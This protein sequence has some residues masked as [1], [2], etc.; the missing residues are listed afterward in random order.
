[1]T[2]VFKNGR[3]YTMNQNQPYVSAVAVQ[4]DK[5]VYVGTNEGARAYEAGAKVIDLDG[6]MMIPG[7]IDA[8]CHPNLHAFLTSGIMVDVDSTKEEVL[9]QIADYVR[10]HPDNET[11][12]GIG[13]PEW[14]FD[15]E[16]GPLKTELDAICADKPMFLMSSG[17]HEGWC[18]SKTFELLNITKETPD[19]VPGFSYFRRSADGE[20][21]GHI[22]E[23]VAEQVLMTSL[24]FFDSEKVMGLYRS[25]FDK[26]SAMGITGF[27]DC[28]TFDSFEAK[29]MDYLETLEKNGELK[30]R[31]CSCVMVQNQDRLKVAVDILKERHAKY[32]SDLFNVNTLKIVNDGTVEVMS[33]STFEPYFDGS[34]AVPMSEGETLYAPCLEAAKAGFDIHIHAIGDKTVHETLMAAKKIREAGYY[35][36]R[37]TNAHSQLIRQDEIPLF[38]KYNVLM[39]SSAI[40]F[41]CSP[42]ITQILGEGRVDRQYQVV[43]VMKEGGRVTLGSDMP[44]DEMGDEPLKGVQMAVTRQLFSDP[45]AEVLAADFERMTVQ[46]AL[47][48]YTINAAY[49]MH[50]EDKT[51]SL[52]V[53][54]YA[55]LV[56]L[57]KDLNEIDPHEIMN[58]QVLLTM[59]GGKTT[60]AQDA[61]AKGI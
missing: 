12:F 32:H 9:E 52:E 10:E 60:Y 55:D 19:P 30:Q 59:M 53:G 43:S 25:M 23:T 33:A 40:W 18:N 38:G 28:G 57:E 35:E 56:V 31:I 15:T 47:E 21:T 50:W 37:I 49:G 11:Y 46:E 26:Y 17:G 8:H 61:F 58:T 14:V 44:F 3:V 27:V 36:N 13:Y 4:D 48:A 2:T 29:A 7:L 42:D 54:K 39:N 6:K 51:G 5:I 16:V 24:P 41:Y 22:V 20:P 34:T 1:M 45:N